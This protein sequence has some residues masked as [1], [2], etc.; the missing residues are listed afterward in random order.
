MS[1]LQKSWKNY[2]RRLLPW[3][4]FNVEGSSTRHAR[5][6]DTLVANQVA[7]NFLYR[8]FDDFHRRR[9]VE[10][11]R[12]LRDLAGFSVARS[13]SGIVGAG[14]GVFV[15][16]GYVREG[17]I[18]ALY[19]GTVYRGSDP[20]FFQSLRNSFVLRCIDGQCID[21]R[22]SGLSRLI[23]R[24]CSNRDRVG[25]FRLSDLSW[26]TERPVNPLAVGQY[27]NNEPRPRMANV[28]YQEVDIADG[29]LPVQLMQYVPN[30]P[31]SHS[32]EWSADP[33]SLRVVALVATRD[34]ECGAELF[35]NY[36]TLLH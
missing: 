20:L 26:L 25:H 5:H 3:I 9:N 13:R 11:D 22:D 35:S 36:F 14:R 32:G 34:V 2:R 30:V 28:A 16:R 33:R 31:F 18:A 27:V 15:T 6:G 23:Y 10:N 8:L 29:A 7:V 1:W 17:A 24:S 4:A 12:S 19:P 21:G